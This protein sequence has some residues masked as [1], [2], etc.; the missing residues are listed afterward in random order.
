M[1][2]RMPACTCTEVEIYYIPGIT[3]GGT[4]DPIYIFVYGF[5]VDKSAEKSIS[6]TVPIYSIY[7]EG[8]IDM[9]NVIIKYLCFIA[10]LY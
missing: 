4:L 3:C 2:K 8:M 7:L 1:C 5:E 6:C 10:F 9:Y